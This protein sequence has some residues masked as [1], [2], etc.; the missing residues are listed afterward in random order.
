MQLTIDL[1]NLKKLNSGIYILTIKKEA[2]K[3]IQ[4]RID[5]YNELLPCFETMQWLSFMISLNL[6]INQDFSNPKVKYK[7]KDIINSYSFRG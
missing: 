4:L 5:K 3:I 1:Y 7:L 6:T 2:F